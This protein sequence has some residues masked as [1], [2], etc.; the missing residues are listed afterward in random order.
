MICPSSLSALLL[1]NHYRDCEIRSKLALSLI[2]GVLEDV[3]NA[4][5]EK[6]RPSV[7][8]FSTTV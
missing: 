1:V 3:R 4:E 7:K 2:F 6:V 5:A 8:L